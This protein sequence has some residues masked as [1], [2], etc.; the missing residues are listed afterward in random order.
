MFS[1]SF[2]GF[3]NSYSLSP[4]TKSGRLPASETFDRYQPLPALFPLF[5]M[6]Y[7]AATGIGRIVAASGSSYNCVVRRRLM[8]ASSDPERAASER[9]S[10]RVSESADTD[11]NIDDDI[12]DDNID[13]IDAPNG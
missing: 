6:R 7:F 2:K 10:E 11:V 12:D 3:E 8:A 4:R 13:I 9:A 5:D 1:D